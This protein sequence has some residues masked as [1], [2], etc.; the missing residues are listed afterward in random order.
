VSGA[1][2]GRLVCDRHKRRFLQLHRPV[3]TGEQSRAER[4]ERDKERE[5]R[6]DGRKS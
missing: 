1:V 2:C 3:Q 4:R 6:N 5:K